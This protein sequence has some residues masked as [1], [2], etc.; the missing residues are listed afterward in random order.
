MSAI[1]ILPPLLISLFSALPALTQT[2]TFGILTYTPPQGWQREATA[3]HIKYTEIKNQTSYCILAI[4][5]TRESTDDADKDFEKEWTDL[6]VK[7]FQVISSPETQKEKTTAGWTVIAG[8]APFKFQGSDGLLML[9]AISGYGK[10]A[11]IMSITNDTS[12]INFIQGFLGTIDIKPGK[13]VTD[14]STTNTSALIGKWGK[15]GSSPSRYI[16]GVL[17]NTAYNGYYKGQYDLKADGSYTFTG[18]S[19]NGL[20]EFRLLDENG[21]Y[22]ITG[23]QLLLIPAKAVFRVTDINGRLRKTEKAVIAKR[24]YNWQLHFFEGIGE[25]N[26]VLTAKEENITDGGFSSNSLFPNSFLY[27]REYKPEWK[28]R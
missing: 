11:S 19:Y 5:N 15:S 2:E 18:E 26:L 9:T 27:S 25:T 8:A 10:T 4:Y 20:N 6:A 23:Q 3:E 28:F 14:S 7:P 21:T 1:K 13:A 17:N 16:N 24:T 12:Y 22:K